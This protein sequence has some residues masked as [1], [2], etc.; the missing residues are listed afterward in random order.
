[1]IATTK[2]QSERM[3][4]CGIPAD[5]A[6]MTIHDFVTGTTSLLAEDYKNF[7]ESDCPEC[8]TPAWSLDKLISILPKELEEKNCTYQ[9]D[10]YGDE[11]F[12]ITDGSPYTLDG[13][14]KIT[15]NG[16]NYII[17]YDWDGFVG[18]PPQS[19][20]LIE[21]VVLAIELLY[22]NDYRFDDVK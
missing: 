12:F 7:R 2:E 15:H 1:M 9:Y 21:A 14:L 4:K 17:D 13:G 16:T 11:G 6:D 5:S 19:K 20:E 8:F 10:N 3:L 18:F 22:A